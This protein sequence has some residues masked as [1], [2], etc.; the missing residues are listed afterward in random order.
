M[1]GPFLRLK[2]TAGSS[3]IDRKR[4]FA[5]RAVDVP[6][7]GSPFHSE[8][9]LAPRAI[10]LHPGGLRFEG[11]V[12]IAHA[13]AEFSRSLVHPSNQHFGAARTADFF[14]GPLSPCRRVVYPDLSFT[15]DTGQIPKRQWKH[16]VAFG[17]GQHRRRNVGFDRKFIAHADHRSLLYRTNSSGM[18]F[19]GNSSSSP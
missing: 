18:K 11:E 1:R 3:K 8:G 2:A 5:R 17:A 13:T 12:G 19:H 16:A 15:E 14:L 9:S 6:T 7:S 4:R 10:N